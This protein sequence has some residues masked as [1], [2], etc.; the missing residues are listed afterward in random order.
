[1]KVLYILRKIIVMSHKKSCGVVFAYDPFCSLGG[2]VHFSFDFGAR[3]GS[4]RRA[5]SP[6]SELR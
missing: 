3:Q 4:T 1:M 6:V 2:E 5:F